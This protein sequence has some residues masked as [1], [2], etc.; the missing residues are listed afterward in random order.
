MDSGVE[1]QKNF[2]KIR[3]ARSAVRG[4]SVIPLLQLRQLDHP[5]AWTDSL[6]RNPAIPAHLTHRSVSL[7][8][9]R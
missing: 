1:S 3:L 8:P 9:M 2:K 7:R 5:Y 4:V 6:C